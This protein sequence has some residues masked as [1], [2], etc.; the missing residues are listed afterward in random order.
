[1]AILLVGVALPA[2]AQPNEKMAQGKIA[3][4]DRSI[5]EKIMPM[6]EQSEPKLPVL[7]IEKSSRVRMGMV[8]HV[9][10][11]LYDA[12]GTPFAPDGLEQAK[13]LKFYIIDR[14][15]SD[16]QLVEPVQGK[17][18]GEY[19]F[20]FGP[21][22]GYDYTVWA[23]VTPKGQ[24]QVSVH[25]E[26]PGSKNCAAPCIDAREKYDAMRNGYAFFL[27][28][29]SQPVA[30][31][32]NRIQVEVMDHDGQLIPVSRMSNIEIIGFY[33]NDYGLFHVKPMT[34]QDGPM[35]FHAYLAHAGF[36]RLFAT[37]TISGQEIMVPFG[38]VVSDAGANSD[39]LMARRNK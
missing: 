17:K 28:L 24:S 8:Q 34:V 4:G 11:T 23:D 2:C 36:I 19:E 7:S 25:A 26:I 21:F 1:M 10:A 38:I 27:S 37:A 12:D 14:S 3:I 31:T 5:P 33:A 18:P 39:S 35:Q 22:T 16:Y 20:T 30:N 15:M 32:S 29:D 13:N 9:A 6:P